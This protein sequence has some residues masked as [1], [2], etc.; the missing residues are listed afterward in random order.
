MDEC[1]KQ[2]ISGTLIDYIWHSF[3]QRSLNCTT[4]LKLKIHSFSKCDSSNIFLELHGKVHIIS[5]IFFF[6]SN[7]KSCILMSANFLL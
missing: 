4:C 7:E 6:F 1:R 3:I 5:L 2:P